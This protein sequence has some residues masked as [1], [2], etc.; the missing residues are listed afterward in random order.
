MNTGACPW[1]QLKL[2]IFDPTEP[3]ILPQDSRA[4]FFLAW[5]SPSG[6]LDRQRAFELDELETVLR[7]TAEQPNIY[8]SQCIFDRPMR[9]SV[10]VQYATHACLDLDTYRVPHLAA[11]SPDRLAQEVRRYCA[12]TGT[13]PPSVIIS[14][15]RGLY[16]KW[17]FTKPAGRDAVGR[18]VGIN[19]ALTRRF[20]CFG[21]DPKA[22]DLARVL[23]VTG[24]IHTG[25]GRLVSLV[26][27][28]QHDRQVVTYDFNDFAA[29]IAPAVD[30]EPEPVDA[31]PE[32]V[33]VLP[34]VADLD[35]EA[36][37]QRASRQFSR[38]GWFW[39]RL[40]ENPR[41]PTAADLLA[42]RQGTGERMDDTLCAGR[43]P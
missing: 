16:L 24:S 18:L 30:A 19:R 26:H 43:G 13:P 36:S 33:L 17:L 15:G 14:S 41:P 12:D 11:L 34:P 10:Y 6:R 32:P 39:S 20:D 38:E 29:L 4:L 9:R 42:L 37:R 28:E 27:L 40:C 1:H 22:I 21:A 8:M 5:L 2:P 35:R 3:R 25:A 31:E 7:L 23:R